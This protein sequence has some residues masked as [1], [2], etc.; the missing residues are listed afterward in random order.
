MTNTPCR[1]SLISDLWTSIN[2]EGYI[3]STAHYIDKN[4]KLNS[5]ILNFYH[6]LA[7]HTSFELCKRMSEFL[8]D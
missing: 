5:K 7:S 1:I 2:I 6:M 3:T 4:W 8:T